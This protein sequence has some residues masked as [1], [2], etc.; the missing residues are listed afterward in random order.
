MEYLK[1]IDKVF[2]GKVRIIMWICNTQLN[3][4]V[5][6]TS[7]WYAPRSM[8]SFL[9]MYSV[10]AA[11]GT[12]KPR[13]TVDDVRM[14]ELRSLIDGSQCNLHTRN[15]LLDRVHVVLAP[16]N[17]NCVFM[18]DLATLIQHVNATHFLYYREL[19][20]L[21]KPQFD[22]HGEPF[23]GIMLLP[24]T[25]PRMLP[26]TCQTHYLYPS[27]TLAHDR[28]VHLTTIMQYFDRV[29]FLTEFAQ[30]V[31]ED[32]MALNNVDLRM[33]RISL[34]NSLK[35]RLLLQ[36]D[37]GGSDAKNQPGDK[38]VD[39]IKHLVEQLDLSIVRN[40][41]YVKEKLFHVPHIVEFP[42]ADLYLNP[43]TQ[44]Q[45]R[46]R[47]MLTVNAS[48]QTS[49]TP[50]AGKQVWV[51]TNMGNYEAT[52]RKGFDTM[53]TVMFYVYDIW[54]R[55]LQLDDAFPLHFLVHTSRT[56][57]DSENLGGVM[58][59]R[60][61]DWEYVLK[62]HLPYCG[63]IY[64]H[65]DA[66]S[67]H[68][69]LPQLAKDLGLPAAATTT[70]TTANND[71]DRKYLFD[72]DCH[73][74]EYLRKREIDIGESGDGDDDESDQEMLLLL[75]RRY[76]SMQCSTRILKTE[77]MLS[78]ADLRNTYM[79]ADVL[80]HTS[81]MEG[82]GLPIVEA[83]V[84]GLPVVAPGD[85]NP[86]LVFLGRTTNNL[87]ES[88]VIFNKGM[89]ELWSFPN[90]SEMVVETLRICLMRV[91]R[92]NHQG[93]TNSTCHNHL[94]GSHML[95]KDVMFSKNSLINP[96]ALS[97]LYRDISTTAD[98][99]ISEIDVLKH[100]QHKFSAQHVGQHH[101]HAF[102]SRDDKN[103]G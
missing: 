84:C 26:K 81:R 7:P 72:V 95:H 5:R 33:Q 97:T 21:A 94:L 8:R 39:E 29:G 98:G 88:N 101:L 57:G 61:F 31:F 62:H 42:W 20:L 82:F 58:E 51:M 35:Q 76:K 75:N 87:I 52:N 44:M 99:G 24:G 96:E 18:N 30:R 46:Q 56:S 38:V 74:S 63:R 90:L 68:Y 15:F 2:A 14:R 3:T 71:N 92:R 100:V 22:D 60:A 9:A 93:S 48:G 78:R 6:G 91:A 1:L 13:L 12:G 27:H 45:L 54:Q 34:K 59:K 23:S 40:R 28:L 66:I 86:E 37:G 80:L 70:T 11:L 65:T 19:Q 89:N 25:T 41:K 85:Y 49:P 53:A 36:S 67:D 17:N 55:I 10:E 77:K 73:L 16:N 83:Q 32:S 47:M 102:L 69:D 79:M 43:L 103:E 50:N 4:Q 64:R